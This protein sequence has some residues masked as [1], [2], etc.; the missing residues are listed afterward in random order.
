MVNETRFQYERQ[1]ENHYP[2]STARTI[3]VSGDF[4][5]GG[6]TGQVYRDHATRLELHNVTTLSHGAHAIKFGMR[7]RDGRDANF[8]D[9][10]FNGSITFDSYTKYQAMA[11]GLAQG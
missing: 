11:N 8:T 5:G 7:L 4:T 6:Y 10:N 1:N 9:A 2:N 3:S